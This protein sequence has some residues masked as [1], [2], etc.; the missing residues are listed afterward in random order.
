MTP[1][2]GA[3]D[4]YPSITP[5][6]PDRHARAFRSLFHTL[7]ERLMVIEE[8]HSWAPHLRSRDTVRKGSIRHFVDPS[9]AVAGLRASSR[10]LLHDAEAFGLLFE[11][12]VIRDLRVYSELLGGE[13]RHYR[14]SAGSEADAIIQLDD[15]RWVAV[16]VKLSPSRAD[17]A[18]RSL[19]RLIAKIDTDRVGAPVAR[20]VITGTGYAYTRPD[21]THVVPLACLAP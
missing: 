6:L 5:A 19:E 10:D 14:D 15:G 16:E 20:L 12:L 17:D 21:G 3:E 1:S 7:I 13:V 11:S 9:L 18:S 4:C 2:A 8:Q